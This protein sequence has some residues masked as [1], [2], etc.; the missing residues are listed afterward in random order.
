MNRVDYVLAL[1]G[2]QGT[3]HTDVEKYFQD[4]ELVKK[5]KEEGN[6]K[7]TLEKA[8]SQQET[9]EYYQTNNIHWLMCKKEWKGLKSIGMEKK[10]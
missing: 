2:N 1:K 8:H 9:R 5:L 10:R 6:Y 7:R 3:L 4:K